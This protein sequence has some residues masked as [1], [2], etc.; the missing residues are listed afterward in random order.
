MQ[1]PN[2][3]DNPNNLVEALKGSTFAIPISPKA[4]SGDV[5]APW[6]RSVYFDSIYFYL[7][8]FYDVLRM[9]FMGFSVLLL[10]RVHST[11]LPPKERDHINQLE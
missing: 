4:R 8:L 5:P 1:I 9:I 11:A 2:N 6:E 3:P 7:F 10:P